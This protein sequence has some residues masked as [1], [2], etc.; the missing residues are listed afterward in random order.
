MKCRYPPKSIV[1]IKLHQIENNRYR[2]LFLFYNV[3]LFQTCLAVLFGAF[4]A[5]NPEPL[6]FL[7]SLVYEGATSCNV[8]M[9]DVARPCLIPF[10]W[11]AKGLVGWCFNFLILKLA[12]HSS[13]VETQLI[14]YIVPPI[15]NLKGNESSWFYVNIVINVIRC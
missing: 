8:A 4:N 9:W 13:S 2:L 3:P 1:P 5:S 12:T 10:V 7:L 15:R 14:N 6:V 11:Y